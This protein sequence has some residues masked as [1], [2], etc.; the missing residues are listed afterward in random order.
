[1][2]NAV[3]R[4][5]VVVGSADLGSTPTEVEREGEGEGEGRRE[6]GIHVHTYIHL[7]VQ[8]TVVTRSI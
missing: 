4:M 1:M 2:V 7:C 3:C 5:V 8:Y 6:S